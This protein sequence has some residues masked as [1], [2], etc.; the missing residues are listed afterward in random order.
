MTQFEVGGECQC[1][2]HGNVTPCLE[3]HHRHRSSRKS[4]SDDKFGD[5]VEADLLVSDGLN[6]ADGDHVEESC[7]EEKFSFTD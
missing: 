5:D 1:L 4:V 6:H 7:G 2:S 3:H